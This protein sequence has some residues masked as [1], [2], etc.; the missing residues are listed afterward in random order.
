M[1]SSPNPSNGSFNG[2]AQSILDAFNGKQEDQPRPS[3][4]D[5]FIW[6]RGSKIHGGG[7]RGMK[8]GFGIAGSVNLGFGVL[9]LAL[10]AKQPG[11]IVPAGIMGAIGFG[12][13]IAT[14]FLFAKY[15]GKDTEVRLTKEGS[16]LLFRLLN[17]VGYMNP[18]QYS[19]T[20]Y[21]SP[22]H[23]IWGI[24]TASNILSTQGFEILE[25]AAAQYVRIN[26]QVE[27]DSNSLKRLS[28]TSGAIRLAAEEAMITLINQ[29]ALLEQH[30]ESLGSIAELAKKEIAKMVELGDRI[31]QS[32]S[33]EDSLLGMH[34]GGSAIDGVLENLRMEQEAL[35]EIRYSQKEE[36]QEERF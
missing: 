11:F 18:H 28:R 21:G 15:R 36:R 2:I 7:I 1:S 13:L 14:G 27:L 29:V 32:I 17:H 30:P 10:T 6:Q 22:W 12:F 8:L 16:Q 34:R 23:R 20:R 3:A 9:F 35:D 26:A 25:S 24:K 19:G 31:E 5:L 33:G 4:L